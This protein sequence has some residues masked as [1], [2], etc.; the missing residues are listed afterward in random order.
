MAGAFPRADMMHLAFA[1]APAYVL[2][3]VWINRRQSLRAAMGIGFLPLVCA[4]LF[5][6]QSVK[7][8]AQGR[9][10]AS[11]V[12]ALRT[13]QAGAPGLA[14]F[15]AT[16]RPGDSMYVHPYLPVLYF[17]TQAR[18]PTRYSYLN[19]GMMTAEDEARV[20]EDL[21]RR[22]PQWVMYLPLTREEFLRIFA[23]GRD[24]DHRFPGIETW[25]RDRY[26]PAEPA[27][28]IGGYTLLRRK[29]DR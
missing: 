2:T 13:S 26:Q 10:V 16:V 27:V 20:L 7:G 21:Q 6:A 25:L 14:N 8:W 1:A 17:W 29:T 3:A 23:S 22:P 11:P 9:N 28:E 19:P 18:N 4:L 24:A 12:G 5:L 15:L